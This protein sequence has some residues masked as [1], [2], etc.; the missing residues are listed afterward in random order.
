VGRLPLIDLHLADPFVQ[1][2]RAHSQ[3]ALDRYDRRPLRR[4]APACSQISRVALAFVLASSLVAWRPAI[5][6]PIE[7][8]AYRRGCI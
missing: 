2:L 4:A 7:G 1:R 6:L 5:I 8:G 3:S